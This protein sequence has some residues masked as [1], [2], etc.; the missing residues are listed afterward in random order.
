MGQDA[1]IRDAML[2]AKRNQPEGGSGYVSDAAI[3]W[4]TT[5][6]ERNAQVTLTLEL[7]VLGGVNRSSVYV[8]LEPATVWAWDE[9]VQ[10]ACAGP[11]AA[12]VSASGRRGKEEATRQV[13]QFQDGAYGTYK[14]TT[15]VPDPLGVL[16]AVP[17]A[18][19]ASG[20]TR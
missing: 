8:F 7:A 19:I 17:P 16:E 1:P 18:P 12:P 20:K 9:G 11:R 2:G 13:F 5:A 4:P 10:W 15:I 6:L 14:S 3:I